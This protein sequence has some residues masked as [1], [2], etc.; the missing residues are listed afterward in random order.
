MLMRLASAVEKSIVL[1]VKTSI[2]LVGSVR[3]GITAHFEK[4]LEFVLALA[5]VVE[6]AYTSYRAATLLLA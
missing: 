1:V 4:L 5:V 3:E 2:H 6:L